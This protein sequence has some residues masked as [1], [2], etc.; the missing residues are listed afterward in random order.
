[1]PVRSKAIPPSSLLPKNDITISPTK[2]YD[3]ISSSFDIVASSYDHNDDYIKLLNIIKKD[4]LKYFKKTFTW[5]HVVLSNKHCMHVYKDKSGKYENMCNKRIDIKDDNNFLCAEHIGIKHR[6]KI[7]KRNIPLN[8]RCNGINKNGKQ[9]E[10]PFKE[11]GYFCK[12]HFQEDKVKKLNDELLEKNKI[13]SNNSIIE[14]ESLKREEELQSNDSNSDSHLNS[15]SNNNKPL[16]KNCY[17]EIKDKNESHS[18]SDISNKVF[19]I[20]N[21]VDNL[22]NT[23]LL[24]SNKFKSLTKY[25]NDLKLLNQNKEKDEV[26]DEL[27]RIYNK[28]KE[29]YNN[30]DNPIELFDHVCDIQT[31]IFNF[32]EENKFDDLNHLKSF[33]NKYKHNEDYVCLI[34]NCFNIID[35]NINSNLCSIHNDNHNNIKNESFIFK[36]E[37]KKEKKEKKE[38]NIINLNKYMKKIQDIEFYIRSNKSIYY[39]YNNNYNK[40][41]YYRENDIKSLLEEFNI[42]YENLNE[43]ISGRFNKDILMRYKKEL[44]LSII[45][46]YNIDNKYKL[47]I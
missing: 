14:R 2:M 8:L 31:S 12:Y 4:F 17:N 19:D 47:Y 30:I 33:I 38:I 42:L 41:I 27:H 39:K 28:N 37:E 6:S 32:L 45:E 5:S 11:N 44:D 21:N 25:S 9:C 20:K 7:K 35:S 34:D 23:I 22:N 3:F 43:D 46:F 1:M 10:L 26:R 15:L 29:N 24:N 36:E 13:I 18:L 40:H 16:L